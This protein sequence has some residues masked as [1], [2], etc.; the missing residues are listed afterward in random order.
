MLEKKYFIE[1]I[2][3]E[4][5]K[6]KFEERI[7]FANQFLDSIC[8]KLCDPIEKKE[9]FFK[10]QKNDFRE[11]KSKSPLLK[12]NCLLFQ[13]RKNSNKTTSPKS[14]ISSKSSSPKAINKQVNHQNTNTLI[15]IKT[16][17]SCEIKLSLFDEKIC[18]NNNDDKFESEK[19]HED[20]FNLTENIDLSIL[21]NK[22]NSKNEI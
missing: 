19:N 12:I 5:E 14:G 20:N 11:S 9:L 3:I 1:N 22:I 4:K 15:N 13:S 10:S 21:K 8:V 2:L 6:I 7:M 17:T 18:Y 16:K